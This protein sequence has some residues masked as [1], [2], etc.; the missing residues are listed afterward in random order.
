MKKLI[1]LLVLF[2][3][4]SYGQFTFGKSEYFTADLAVDFYAS[5]KESGLDINARLGL[6]SYWGYITANIQN[7]AVLEGG[8]TDLVGSFG[9]NFQTDRFNTVRP[10]VGGRLGLIFKG[11]QTYPTAGFE[12]GLDWNINDKMYLGYRATGDYRTDYEFWGSDPA[13]RYSS[14]GVIGI[15]W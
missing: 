11:S 1:A 13:M 8:Y 9:L 5:V 7:F 12:G 10:Y 14:Y 15:K 3:M 6:V 2:P 4:F